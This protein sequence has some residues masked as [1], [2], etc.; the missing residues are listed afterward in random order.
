MED[1]YFL[2]KRLGCVLFIFFFNEKFLNF[3]NTNL[4]FCLAKSILK[5]HFTLVFGS[6][7]SMSIK[8]KK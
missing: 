5:I 2:S 4:L 1:L 3:Q 7:Y 6:W 8:Y